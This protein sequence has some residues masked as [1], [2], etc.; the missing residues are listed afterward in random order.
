MNLFAFK[1]EIF[2]YLEERFKS[3]LEENKDS[4]DTC[5]Y[6]I[7]TV[8]F[9]QIKKGKVTCKILKTDAVWHGM[10]YKEDKNELTSAIDEMIKNNIYP[11][12]LWG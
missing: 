12:K 3:F 8:V 9:E 10:T 7:P 4:L 1:P 5:E 6:L 2:D 11:E